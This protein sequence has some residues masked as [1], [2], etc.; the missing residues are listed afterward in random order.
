M[1]LLGIDVGLGIDVDNVDTSKSHRCGFWFSCVFEVQLLSRV[2]AVVE[3]VLSRLVV[4]FLSNVSCGATGLWRE[5]PWKQLGSS[6]EAAYIHLSNRNPHPTKIQNRSRHLHG[7]FSTH[8]Y[9]LR[10]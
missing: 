3:M 9:V 6:L 1:I 10:L 2:F 8:F 4:V 7:T 5:V